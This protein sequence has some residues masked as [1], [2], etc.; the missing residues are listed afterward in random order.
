MKGFRVDRR[1][2]WDCHGLPV[3][4]AVEKE[5]G[6]TGKG[7]IEAYGVA[8]FNARCRESVTRHVDEFT[9]LTRRM[10]YWVDLD[11]AYWTMNPAYV[12]SVWWSLQQIFDKGLLVEDHRVAPYCPR[13]G[14]GL[15]DHEVAQGYRTVTDPSVYVRFPVTSG[16]LVELG[17]SLLVWTTT[18]W[19]LVSNT[20]VAVHPDVTYVVARRASDDAVV[21]VAEPL[22]AATVGE[23]A[24]V[25]ESFPGQRPGAHDLRPAVRRWSTSPRAPRRTS[26]AL[27]DYVTVTDG[28]GLVHQAPAFGADDLAVGRRYGLPVVNPVKADGHFAD[29]V[30]LVGGQFFKSADADLVRDLDA[31]GLLWREL[32]VRAQ[33]PALL[34]LRHRAA[35][36]RA[37]LLVHPHHRRARP[38]AGGERAAPTGTR[39]PSSTAA[40]ATG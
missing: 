35:L 13:C 19:T 32:P 28:T 9:D 23:D 7:D 18:P 30:P 8:E 4:L 5:L 36:L 37:A 6:F 15:S 10:G 14:T 1:A 29:D 20:A 16:P 31:R 2:G 12:E 3:E 39:R 26:S 11:A 33:L 22:L 38:A 34:A 40:S 27:A 25:L 17:A 21:V 24:E